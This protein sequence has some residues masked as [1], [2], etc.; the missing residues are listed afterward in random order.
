MPPDA[1]I[2][3]LEGPED[4]PNLVDA[5]RRRGYDGERLDAIL[6]GNLVRLFRRGLPA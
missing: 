5:L 2:E 3:G 1:S 4:Y 6:G